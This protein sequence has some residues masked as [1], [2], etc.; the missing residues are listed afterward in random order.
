MKRARYL[1]TIAGENREKLVHPMHCTLMCSTAV[2]ETDRKYYLSTAACV[3]GD[4]A[5]GEN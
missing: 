2:G 1:H 3:R 4:G 5:A